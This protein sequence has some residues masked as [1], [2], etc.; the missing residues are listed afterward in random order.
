MFYLWLY[1]SPCRTNCRSRGW[2]LAPQGGNAASACNSIGRA[3]FP[4]LIHLSPKTPALSFS[5]A[6]GD[7]SA[8]GG[9]QFATYTKATS[10]SQ[11][12]ALQPEAE[13]CEAELSSLRSVCAHATLS[14]VHLL[15]LT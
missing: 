10:R 11:A 12:L 8:S 15:Q 6:W 4:H 3:S 5:S 14:P 1:D 13:V 9:S 2:K 7:A